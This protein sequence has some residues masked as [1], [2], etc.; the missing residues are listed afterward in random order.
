MN[1]LESPKEFRLK[2]GSKVM[3]YIKRFS[4]TEKTIF[5]FFVILACFSALAM[6]GMVSDL[7]SV[8]IPKNGGSFREGVIG[9]PHNI[10]PVLAT[11]EADRDISNLVYSG[12]M[13]YQDGNLE[14][15]IAESYSISEDGLSYIFTLKPD[16]HFHDG[17]SIT[18]EDVAFTIQKI[19][20]SAIK[21]PRRADWNDISIEIIS[22]REIKFTLKQPYRPF[23]YNT[24]VGIIPKHIW[25]NLSDDQF[26]FSQYNIE[27][28]GSGPYKYKSIT[29]NA[30]G[31]PE[32]Y[33]L[34]ANNKYYGKRAYIDN[35]TFVFFSDYEKAILALEKGTIDSLA[36]VSASDA[37]K[38]SDNLK[39]G[40]SIISTPLPRIFGLFFNQ[41]NNEV[42]A[43]KYVRQALNV[44][45]DRENIIKEV[46]NGFGTSI[47]GPFPFDKEEEKSVFNIKADIQTAEAI[48]NKG[49]WTKN[50]NTGIFEKKG[51][52][53]TIQILSLSI[54]TADTPDLKQTAEM[55]KDAWTTL[56]VKVTVKIFDSSELYQNI[57]RPRKYDVLLFG[58]LIGKDRDVYAFWHSSQRN[59]PGLNVAMYANSNADQIIEA[60]RR[61]DVDNTKKGNYTELSNIIKNDV[62]AVF[63]YSPDFI[64]ISKTNLKN[65]KNGGF[66]IKNITIPSD[67]FNSINNW[68]IQTEKVWK[69]FANN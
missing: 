24:T 48:L 56:G 64:Y 47:H 67:R 11:T 7:F 45:V 25:N 53:N 55:V 12:L 23:I 43:D 32:E 51:P 35:I 57:I 15:D 19:Q 26:I 50:P 30:E 10:N 42:L 49:G 14:K 38:L 66:E 20:N 62:P 52:K 28:I 46:L 44:A 65:T 18:A 22:S 1:N 63:L 13:K 6:A 3:N 27:P 31:I 37:K 2:N 8:Q 4:A 16:I 29:K 34:T 33:N 69:I 40:Y 68:Y 36:S 39:E 61:D 5:A 54:Y 41:N 58:Q 59:T 9:L 60:I 17:T 21:S